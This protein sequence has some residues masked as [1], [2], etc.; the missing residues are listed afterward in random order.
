MGKRGP[1]P[2][3]KALAV[4]KGVYQPV[5]HE[6][7][8]GA[9]GLEFITSIPEPISEF[10]EIGARIWH[11]VCSRALNIKGWI[12]YTDLPLLESYCFNVQKMYELREVPWVEETEQGRR[13]SAE[14]Q[15]YR[16][17]EKMAKAVGDLFGLNPSARTRIKLEK[18]EDVDE[19]AKFQF[20]D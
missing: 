6:D 2:Q 3:P 13:V 16:D 5:R 15:I 10:N 20:Q 12:A 17:S 14:Y 11:G 8:I 18:P 4:A 19:F 9:D 7:Q 1:T